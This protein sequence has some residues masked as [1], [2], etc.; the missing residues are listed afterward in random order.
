MS[1]GVRRCIQGGGGKAWK[2][3]PGTGGGGVTIFS[4]I[5][6]NKNHFILHG[7]DDNCV[8]IMFFR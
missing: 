2:S 3:P 6:A 1:E 5:F 8:N 7:F 4:F